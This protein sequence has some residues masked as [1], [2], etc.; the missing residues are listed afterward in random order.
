MIRIGQF[1]TIIYKEA[2]KAMKEYKQL[3]NVENAF[4]ELKNFL[5][6]RPIY[7]WKIRRV[8]AHIFV[9]VLSYLIESII[10]KSCTQ[11]ARSVINELQTIK[12][13]NIKAGKKEIKKISKIS[14]ENIQIIEQLKI[15]LP[16]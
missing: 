16:L 14:Y 9:S 13:I 7:H 5:D 3:Q 2:N 8:K 12:R 4:D 15:Q 6:I 10:E 11:S 1:S